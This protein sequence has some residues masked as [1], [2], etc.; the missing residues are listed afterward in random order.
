MRQRA[1]E[2]KSMRSKLTS[3][4][5]AAEISELK[6]GA[7][8]SFKLVILFADGLA[9]KAVAGAMAIRDRSVLENFIVRCGRKMLER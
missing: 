3:L 8:V 7:G 2:I 4:S 6:N 1:L 5:R 9:I